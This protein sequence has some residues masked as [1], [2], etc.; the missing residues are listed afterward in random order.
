M[1]R[2]FSPK[3]AANMVLILMV[4]G[5]VLA[6]MAPSALGKAAARGGGH[7]RRGGRF[8]KGHLASSPPAHLLLIHAH[9][10]VLGSDGGIPSKVQT[11]CPQDIL[12]GDGLALLTLAVLIG[13]TGDEAD[14]LGQTFLDCFLCIIGYFGVWRENL[15][16]DPDN[17]SDWHEAVLFSHGALVV[18]RVLVV[19]CMNEWMAATCSRGVKCKTHWHKAPPNR[20]MQTENISSSG[21]QPDR[22]RA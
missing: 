9:P 19:V 10:P 16:H 2:I 22:S 17:V 15:A 1:G 7:G 21:T 13:F 6:L 8:M 14:V 4:I 5:I 3:K 20:G 18:I 12:S 11:H